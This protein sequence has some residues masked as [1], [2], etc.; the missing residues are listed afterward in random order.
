VGVESNVCQNINELQGIG[1]PPKQRLGMHRHAPTGSPT[2]LPMTRPLGSLKISLPRFATAL[3]F[4]TAGLLSLVFEHVDHWQRIASR[5][6]RPSQPIWKVGLPDIDTQFP[7]CG[8][9]SRM[10]PPHILSESEDV[11]KTLPTQI[12]GFWGIGQQ[13]ANYRWA[14][15]ARAPGEVATSFCRS[16]LK[17]NRRAQRVTCVSWPETSL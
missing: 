13:V 11:R 14:R 7:V 12:V 2:S 5:G 9:H 3:I 1:T 16:S 4:F 6:D 15:E 8:L 17:R 10:E